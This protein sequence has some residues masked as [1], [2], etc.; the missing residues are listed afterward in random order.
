[1][2]IQDQAEA[3]HDLFGVLVAALHHDT[4]VR[5]ILQQQLEL[6]AEAGIL[7]CWPFAAVSAK[8][9][10]L[11]A[12]THSLAD[13]VHAA[14]NMQRLDHLLPALYQLMQLF[15]DVSPDQSEALLSVLERLA[16]AY[17]KP[18]ISPTSNTSI[19]SILGLW[20]F[21]LDQVIGPFNV[22]NSRT[23]SPGSDFFLPHQ[24]LQRKCTSLCDVSAFAAVQILEDTADSLTGT[25]ELDP[26]Y[27]V[28]T[29]AHLV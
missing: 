23:V 22:W 13:L 3:I 1:M 4:D 28:S 29:A 8:E 26:S 20:D 7:S 21:N 27:L 17:G 9:Q 24:Q 11:V 12:M 25:I 19:C 15:T 14:Y 6:A 10:S 18:G 5:V 16:E 2:L